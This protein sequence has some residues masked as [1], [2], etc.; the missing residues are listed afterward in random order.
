M[1]GRV[2]SITTGIIAD[3]LVF[4]MDAANRASYIPNA[5]TSYNTLDL[6]QSGSLQD[7]NGSGMYS[8]DNQGTW[9]FD[10]I[11]DYIQ[12][13]VNGKGTIFDTQTFTIQAWFKSDIDPDTVT[14]EV[15]WSYD[16]N[17][18]TSPYYSQHLRLGG[19]GSPQD[20]IFFG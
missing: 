6:N 19:S 17:G 16:K 7:D 9:V 4:N 13:L 10:G 15:I 3:G 8:S 2:G 5:T 12:P 11:D 14:A 18:H 20:E 1:S